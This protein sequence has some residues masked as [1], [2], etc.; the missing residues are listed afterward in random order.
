MARPADPFLE[1]SKTNYVT[2]QENVYHY[3][4]EGKYTDSKIQRTLKSAGSFLHVGVLTHLPVG[5]KFPFTRSAISEDM[6]KEL[7][8]RVQKLF[9]Q[10]YDM[11]SYVVWHSK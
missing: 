4:R 5:E 10:A 9:F 2:F 8:K 7:A 11:E 6:L 3:L 1:K